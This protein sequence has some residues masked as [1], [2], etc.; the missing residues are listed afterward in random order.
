MTSALYRARFRRAVGDPG[1]DEPLFE[2][3]DIDDKFDQAAEVYPDGSDEALLAQAVIYGFEDLM[4]V[5]ATQ[6][7]YTANSASERLGSV[8]GNYE[9]LIK[10]WETKLQTA[11]AENLP[12]VMWGST[13]V[14]PRRDAEYPDA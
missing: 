6:V 3:D 2:T 10:K 11:L 9:K 1:G 4:A 7:D 14:A 13:S 12:M 5:Y 8:F